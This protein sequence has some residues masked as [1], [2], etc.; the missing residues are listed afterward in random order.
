MFN[1]S[2]F[3]PLD[4]YDGN[5]DVLSDVEFDSVAVE[6]CFT[7][8]SVADAIDAINPLLNEL[9][10]GLLKDRFQTWHT[11]LFRLSYSDRENLAD[12]LFLEFFI[13]IDNKRWFA[14]DSNDNYAALVTT[15]IPVCRQQL[16]CLLQQ[17]NRV[18]I[19]QC[20]W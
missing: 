9:A 8:L 17:S 1:K 2:Y 10:I 19:T 5:G 18:K 13:N 20:D 16:E 15:S 7:F 4:N 6:I 11:N 12:A 3:S 14:F